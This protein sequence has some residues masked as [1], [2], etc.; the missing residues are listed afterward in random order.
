LDDRKNVKCYSL[1]YKDNHI[2]SENDK[3]DVKSLLQDYYADENHCELENSFETNKKLNILQNKLKKM[4]DYQ[5][6]VLKEKNKIH[7][8]RDTI[9]TEHKELENL[10]A[11]NAARIEKIQYFNPKQLNEYDLIKIKTTSSF[12]I[13]D[14]DKYV[15]NP[16]ELKEFKN[17]K[18]IVTEIENLRAEYDEKLGKYKNIIT[19]LKSRLQNNELKNNYK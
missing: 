1:K 17:K 16:E 11:K 8:L 3:F 9:E 14:L 4:R 19:K 10:K 15:N 6:E 7:T 18:E 12:E 5:E 2:H 13:Q